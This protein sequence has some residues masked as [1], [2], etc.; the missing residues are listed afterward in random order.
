[1]SMLLLLMTALQSKKKKTVPAK[2]IMSKNETT[3]LL[4]LFSEHEL[5]EQYLTAIKTPALSLLVQ[6]KQ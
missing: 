6:E 2:Y 1:M 4:S 5:K 3:K